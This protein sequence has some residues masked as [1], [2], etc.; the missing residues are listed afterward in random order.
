[1]RR[2]CAKCRRLNRASRSASERLRLC[3]PELSV[4]SLTT[5]PP[6]EKKILGLPSYRHP[7]RPPSRA[8]LP[9]TPRTGKGGRSVAVE[10][11]R[12][13]K[14]GKVR[15]TASRTEK[16]PPGLFH[17]S[18]RAWKSRQK[19]R[20]AISTFPQ[21]RRRSGLKLQYLI[22]GLRSTVVSP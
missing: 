4:L 1:M 9:R 14:R 19:Q 22:F 16:L 5:S 8:A 21:R 15:S 3:G 20:R 2:M 12:R 11:T 17:A 7:E 10:M 13:G 6:W 18:H